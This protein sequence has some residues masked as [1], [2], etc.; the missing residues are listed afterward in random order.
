MT[1]L[2]VALCTGAL[3]ALAAGCSGGPG[4]GISSGAGATLRADVLALT[5]AVARH[6]W[7]DADTALAQL[8]ADL[9]T[10]TAGGGVNP[11]QADAIRADIAAI[12]T[13]LG[14]QR[15]AAGRSSSSSTPS[16]PKPKPQPKPDPKPKPPKPP[17]PHGDH[18]HGHGGED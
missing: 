9:A 11:V 4:A 1:R 16:S 13:D 12:A 7:S 18:G 17:K 10:A 5:Q 6:Q 3:C 2:R 15:A 8:R 14:A